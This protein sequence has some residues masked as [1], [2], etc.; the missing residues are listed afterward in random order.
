MTA[1][2]ERIRRT[3]EEIYELLRQG[4]YRALERVTGG[5]RL[6]ATDLEDAVRQYPHALQSRP[7]GAPLNIVE[8]TNSSPRACR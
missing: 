2:D 5:V 3:V 1:V 6:S 4:Q 7:P 8:I